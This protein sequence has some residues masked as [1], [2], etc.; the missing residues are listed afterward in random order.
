[1][2][3]LIKD[4]TN[5]VAERKDDRS[6]EF[7]SC[8]QTLKSSSNESVKNISVTEMEKIVEEFKEKHQDLSAREMKIS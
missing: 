7:M 8:W 1:M 6:A 4:F 3:K 2:E 5:I